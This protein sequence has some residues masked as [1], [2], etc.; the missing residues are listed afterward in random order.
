M[1]KSVIESL[2]KC[3]VFKGITEE[4][5][6]YIVENFASFSLWN[7]NDIIFSEQNYTRSLVIITKGS[8]AVTKNSEN[9][10]I[11]MS[12]LKQGDVFGM[13]TLFYEEDEYLT[14]NSQ[15]FHE[16]I[17]YKIVAKYHECGSKFGKWYNLIEME[18]IIGKHTY[19]PK[20]FI[21]FEKLTK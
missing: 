1:K 5:I 15:R 19:P 8:A 13:A 9:S 10:Q 7:K 18:K 3:S 11:L 16:A 20:E 12:I 17:G 6:R 2:S 14:R 21:P 4:D